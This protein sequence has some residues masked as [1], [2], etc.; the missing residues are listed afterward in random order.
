MCQGRDRTS[1]NL[2]VF[3]PGN[4]KVP[5]SDER[6]DEVEIFRVLDF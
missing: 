4:A 2:K 6:F 5:K 3:K 1:S